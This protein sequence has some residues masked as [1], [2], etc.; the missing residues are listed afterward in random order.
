MSTSFSYHCP[1]RQKPITERNWGVM[2][3][4]GNYSAFNGYYFTPSDY[5][6]VKCCSCN[7]F[8]RTKAKYVIQLQDERK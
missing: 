7:A 5:S 6:S 4:N 3:R 2:V 8:G 1:E